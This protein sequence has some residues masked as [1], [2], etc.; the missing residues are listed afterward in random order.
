M[1]MLLKKIM[2]ILGKHYS[3]EMFSLLC[4]PVDRAHLRLAAAKAILRLSKQW[5]HKIPLNIFYLAL[6]LGTTQV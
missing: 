2:L 4:S 5:E 6:G 3:S 1:S